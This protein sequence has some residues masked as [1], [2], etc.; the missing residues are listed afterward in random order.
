MCSTVVF[1]D[2]QCVRERPR[3][4]VSCSWRGWLSEYTDILQ[5]PGPDHASSCVK[6]LAVVECW[7]PC[8]FAQAGRHVRTSARTRAYRQGHTHSV[9]HVWEHDRLVCRGYV[10]NQ[11]MTWASGTFATED[12]NSSLVVWQQG[13][14]GV[15]PSAYVLPAARCVVVQAG[16][17][18]CNLSSFSS[19]S[20]SLWLS[21][22]WQ[23][24]PKD[25]KAR[26]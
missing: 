6:N 3:Q 15:L 7:R 18:P 11:M 10:M 5:V 21:I 2:A 25:D 13:T 4:T 16:P 19:K 17:R 14:G 24:L 1:F 8:E 22:Q 20:E 23:G 12:E 9:S 26:T